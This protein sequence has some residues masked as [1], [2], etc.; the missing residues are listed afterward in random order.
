[1]RGDDRDT[2]IVKVRGRGTSMAGYHFQA[3]LPQLTVAGRLMGVGE[4]AATVSRVAGTSGAAEVRMLPERVSLDEVE[5]QWRR[6]GGGRPGQVPFGIS[7]VGLLPAVAD[8]GAAPHLLLAGNPE[9]G[10]SSALRTLATSVMRAYTPEQA[11]IYVVDPHTSLLQVVEGPHLGRY[12]YREQQVRDLAKEVAAVLE[13]RLPPEDATQAELAAGGR[14]SGPH[15]FVFVDNEEAVQSWDSGNI[16]A[17]DGGYPLKPLMPYVDR[18]KEIGFHI[19]VARQIGSWGRAMGS[20]LAGRLL[21]LRVPG[22]VM[23]G[24]R[25]EGPIIGNV[26]AAEQPPG[27]GIYVTDKL[28]APV[29]FAEAVQG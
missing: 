23:D 15:V 11:R 16:F 20:P 13:T 10:L 25:S 26:R 28:A 5:A 27:R 21:Q 12:T 9:C 7:E 22:V 17:E 1:M 6:R 29:H 19:V 3:G 18:G 24:D 2:K 14:W 8:F 4:A